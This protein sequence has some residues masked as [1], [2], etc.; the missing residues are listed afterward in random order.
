MEKINLGNISIGG[1]A[2][3][4]AA[5]Q[6]A[7]LQ[8]QND[9]YYDTCEDAKSCD[10]GNAY[11]ENQGRILDLTLTLKCVCP[12]KRVALGVA[13]S[14][15]DACNQEYSRGL[16]TM[17]IP[18]HNNSCCMDIPVSSMRFILPEDISVSG[19]RDMCASQRHFIARVDAHYIDVI[20][21][22]CGNCSCPL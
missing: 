17:T 20:S 9:I 3:P 14:E 22:G 4:A 11:M 7:P 13:L 15:V 18:A 1:M 16:K 8:V 6:A 5:V 10:M 2:E 21:G 19:S 12:G